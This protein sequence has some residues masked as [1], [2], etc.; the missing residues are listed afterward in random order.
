MK[1]TN[2]VFA[3]IAFVGLGIV[4]VACK[5]D[6]QKEEKEQ[7]RTTLF[8]KSLPELK[9]LVDGR[10]ELVSGKNATEEGEFENTFIT[11]NGDKYIWTEEGK[12]EPG[13][14]NWRKGP[15]GSGYDAWLMD[16]FYAERPAYPLAISGDTLYIQD[17]SATGYKYTLIRKKK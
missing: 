15:A 4:G 9:A 5:S 10:W 17:I 2:L 8:D 14:L 7:V 1:L 11:F 6:K 16:V 12:D 3:I 13:E